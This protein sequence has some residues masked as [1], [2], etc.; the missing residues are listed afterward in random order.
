MAKQGLIQEF[1]EFLTTGDLM[2][3]A[4]AFVMGAA[5]KA[6]IDSFV[7]NIFGGIL[8]IF[9]PDSVSSLGGLTAGPLKTLL[10]D[11]DK[12]ATGDNVLGTGRPLKYG[13][14]IQDIINFVILAFVV[15]MI[16]KAYKKVVKK[17]L[18]SEGPG[19]NDILGEIRDLLKSGR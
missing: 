18:A 11:P 19:T 10:K 16:V 15:F 6:V 13:Q 4:V 2:S 17:N 9:L 3:V 8:S 7:A 12:P 14:F 5:T 1:K